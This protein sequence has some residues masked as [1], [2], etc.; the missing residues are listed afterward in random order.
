MAALCERTV[1]QKAEYTGNCRWPKNEFIN[2]TRYHSSEEGLNLTVAH[3]VLSPEK[4]N[5]YNSM[6]IQSTQRQQSRP[7]MCL[8]TEK[9]IWRD[10]SKLTKERQLNFTGYYVLPLHS[11]SS[12]SFLDNSKIGGLSSIIRHTD[13]SDAAWTTQLIA[14]EDGGV[15]AAYFDWKNE[16]MCLFTCRHLLCDIL[17]TT[18]RY[19]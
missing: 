9:N 1:G 10:V 14:S 11:V 13:T 8:A 6:P 15:F 16:E 5:F 12:F 4:C 19:I 2:V 18:V 17:V 7:A 3:V